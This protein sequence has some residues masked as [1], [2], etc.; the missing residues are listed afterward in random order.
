VGT[1]AAFKTAN[2]MYVLPVEQSQ[3]LA[4]KLRVLFHL[5][6]RLVKAGGVIMT[7]TKLLS[8]LKIVETAFAW[9]R[10]RRFVSSA[11][12]S[13]VI[14][15]HLELKRKVSR[16][17]PIRFWVISVVHVPDTEEAVEDEQ[18]DNGGDTVTVFKHRSSGLFV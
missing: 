15:S 5:H 4:C 3:S 11:G 2:M 9:I 7:M 8:Q 1:K 10:V 14:P 16:V 18:H 13:Q 17:S 6:W 12:N